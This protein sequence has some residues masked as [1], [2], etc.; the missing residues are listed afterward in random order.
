MKKLI[1]S[2][3]ALAFMVAPAHALTVVCTNCSNM[4]TQAL[5]RVTNMEQL[6][7]MMKEYQEAIQQTQQQIRMVQQNIEQYQNMLQNTAQLPANLVGELRGN[8]TRLANLSSNLKTLRG[9]VTALGSVFTNLFPDKV[10][11]TVLPGPGL[12]KWMR[13][14]PATAKPGMSGRPT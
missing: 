8:L 3:L 1:F 10:F 6:S 2:L 7:T 4:F 11:W 12:R 14:M 13:P 9:D 5:E